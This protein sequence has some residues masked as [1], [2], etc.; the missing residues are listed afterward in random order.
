MPTLT[1][2]E[3]DFYDIDYFYSKYK[4]CYSIDISK[5]KKKSLHI[6]LYPK[7]LFLY[8]QTDPTPTKITLYSQYYY[9]CILYKNKNI[10]CIYLQDS[11]HALDYTQVALFKDKLIYRAYTQHLQN[12]KIK[13]FNQT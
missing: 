10:S 8:F 2:I 11:K 9:I 3:L 6:L 13:L 4:D 7:I 12:I 1:N 5:L